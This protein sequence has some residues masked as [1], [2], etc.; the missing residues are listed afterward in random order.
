M[1][2]FSIE[3]YRAYSEEIYPPADNLFYVSPETMELPW[4]RLWRKQCE[5]TINLMTGP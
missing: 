2:G 3:T 5:R 4:K 1:C